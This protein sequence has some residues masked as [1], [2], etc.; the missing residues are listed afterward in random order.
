MVYFSMQLALFRA[1]PKTLP[2]LFRKIPPALAIFNG[3]TGFT[4]KS[5]LLTLLASLSK[6]R[7]L[8]SF[9]KNIQ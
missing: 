3:I 4:A 8:N 5:G 6:I 7:R 2:F 9:F 1:G